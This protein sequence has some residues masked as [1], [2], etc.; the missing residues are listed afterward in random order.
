MIYNVPNNALRVI[1]TYRF[2]SRD[3]RTT[4][5][6]GAD[7]RSLAWLGALDVDGGRALRT[8]LNI[9]RNRFALAQ[10]VIHETFERTSVEEYVLVAVVRLDEA[11]TAVGKTCDSSCHSILFI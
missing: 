1:V 8:F 2:P 7:G 4:V 11:E 9:E 10:V 3:K 6:T 5:G